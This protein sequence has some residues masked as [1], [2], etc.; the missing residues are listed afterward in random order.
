MTTTHQPNFPEVYGGKRVWVTGD[1]GFKG[2]WLAF[3][4]QRLGAKVFGVGLEPECGEGLFCRGRLDELIHHETAD[5]RHAGRMAAIAREV[6]PDIV[7]H[8]AAQSLVR[9]SYSIPMETIATNVCG[10][11]HILEALRRRGK[12]C[13]VV[14]ITSDKCYLNREQDYAYREDDPLGGH[15]PYSASK[16]CAELAAAAYRQS[17]FA[18]EGK[19]HLATARAGNVI[20]PGDWAMDRIGPDAVRALQNGM[21]LRVRNPRAIRPW[22]HVLEPLHGYLLLGKALLEKGAA[23]AEAW[24]FGPNPD[25]TRSVADLADLFCQAWG[26]GAVWMP[27]SVANSPHEAHLLQ[28]SIE[29]SVSRL[30]WRPR[31]NFETAVRRTAHG[32]QSLLMAP[33]ADSVRHLIAAEIAAYESG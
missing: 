7:F 18:P 26:Q 31:W 1:T 4:L 32:Y 24:N 10:T 23:F 6:D 11:V 30:N 28:L 8:L 13:A 20:G 29:K 19:I 16:A 12:P 9:R 14:V 22:Q 3:W 5:I 17:F 27:V 21:P 33:D 25:S 15:D 2:S